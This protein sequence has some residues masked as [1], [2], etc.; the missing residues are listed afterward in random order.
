MIE[1]TLG[2]WQERQTKRAPVRVL[3]S[4]PP[5]DV[6]AHIALAALDDDE[7]VVHPDRQAAFE[8]LY[9]RY[10]DR[11]LR[12]CR[13][14]IENLADAE[15]TAAH[16]LAR[17]Y[18]G[19][20]PDRRS[21]FRAWLFTIAH[22][23]VVDFYR[24]QGSR[25]RTRP[26]DTSEEHLTDP[27]STPEKLVLQQE[28]RRTLRRALATLSEDQRQVVELRLAGL[29]GAEIAAVVGRSHNAVKMLQFRA[30]RRLRAVLTAP[31]SS[32]SSN[33]DFP[34]TREEQTDAF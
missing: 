23:A 30:L 29:K 25:P 5:H 10:A 17:A 33:S 4:A 28:D 16:I 15:D 3:A 12:Y 19:F 7:L 6:R 22:H 8:A 18:G 27:A 13:F 32:F 9:D 2:A 1:R 21:T 14:R 11:V 34:P 26:L 31:G 24:R 20:P